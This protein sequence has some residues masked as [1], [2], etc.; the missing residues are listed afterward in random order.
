MRIFLNFFIPLLLMPNF[1]SNYS[2]TEFYDIHPIRNEIGLQVLLKN[3]DY[4]KG[5]IDGQ[6]GPKSTSA[7][8]QFQITAGI[9][10]DGILGKE[11]CTKF[12]NIN[13]YKRSTNTVT[14]AISIDNELKDVQSKLKDLGLYSG[15]IDGIRGSRTTNAIKTFQSKAGLIVDGV[16]GPNTLNALDKGEDAYVETTSQPDITSKSS[17][18]TNSIQPSSSSV[19]LANYNPNLTCITGYVNNIGIWV[20]DPC[21]YPVFV[22]RFGKVAQVNSAAERDAYL[23]DRWSLTAE[24]IYTPIGPVNTQNYSDGINSP[25]NGMIMPYGKSY[26][27]VVLGI[28]NDN[29]LRARPQSGPQ[30]ADAVFEVLVEGG[31]TR[32]INVFYQSDTSYHGPIR[33]ARPTDPTV[34]RPVNGVLVASGATSGLIP[35]IL[36]MGVPVI[37]DQRSGYFRISSHP[38]GTNRRA[39]HNLY[40]DTNLLRQRAISSGYKPSFHPQALFPWG[41]PDIADWQSL[42][43]ITLTFSNYTKATWTWNGSN[44][45]R[46]YYDAYVGSSNT[47]IH[48]S[49]SSSGVIDQIYTTTV[50]SLFC[51]PYIHPLQLPSVKTVGEGRAIIMHGGKMLDAFWK[52]GDNSDPFHIVDINGNEL[53][54]PKGKVWISLV[55]NT[56]LPSFG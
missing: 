28:K 27:N 39:P 18:P 1:N 22:Y 33:S 48:N 26:P 14:V 50:I 51:E 36:D 16:L 47:N 2:C 7:I 35:E 56:K 4:Y 5:K 34:L 55:P 30:N 44:Y 21:F 46:T 9:S 49:I 10:A 8:K 29:N 38:S 24:K 12:L 37:S 13:D 3:N 20:P 42:S 54:V 17:T 52:R 19:D 23:A 31:M 40:A 11:T 6:I 41:D 43:S 53:F 32:F 25:V 45:I 15:E